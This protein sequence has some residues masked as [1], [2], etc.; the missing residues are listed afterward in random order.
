MMNSF[1][2]QRQRRSGE[3]AADTDCLLNRRLLESARV[4]AWIQ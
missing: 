2:K 1:I 3:S 4:G